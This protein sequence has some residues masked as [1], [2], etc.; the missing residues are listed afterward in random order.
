MVSAGCFKK[1]IGVA[2]INVLVGLKVEKNESLYS[3]NRR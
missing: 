2:I 1:N 3:Q